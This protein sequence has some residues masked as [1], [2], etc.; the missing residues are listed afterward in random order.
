MKKIGINS[1][2]KLMQEKKK[3]IAHQQKMAH[4]ELN[5][6]VHESERI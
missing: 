1:V 5:L 6:Q 2:L 3:S 4:Q